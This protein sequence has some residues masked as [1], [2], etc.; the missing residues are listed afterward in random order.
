[1]SKHQKKCEKGDCG[2]SF[3]D[4][5]KKPSKPAKPANDHCPATPKGEDCG[6]KCP[7]KKGGACKP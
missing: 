6:G 4:K 5:A 2:K 7:S 3:H 1:M